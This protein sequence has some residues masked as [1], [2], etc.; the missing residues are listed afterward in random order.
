MRYR[1]VDRILE[2]DAHGLGTI[3]TSKAFAR[4]EEFFD[5][6]F[7]RQEEVPSLLVLEA[8]AA[9]GSFLLTVK[10]RYQIHALLLKVNRAAFLRPVLAGDQLIVRSRLAGF[11]GDWDR[12]DASGAVF[13][14]AEV[15]AE[16]TVG[17]DPAADAA[18]LFVGLPLSRTLGGRRNEVLTGMLELL[19]YVDTRP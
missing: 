13:G 10:S 2:I 3:T 18:L 9:A 14:V 16:C 6:T 11:Q 1:F 5:G 12:A 7:R 4:S 17:T 19:G 15:Q 8:M